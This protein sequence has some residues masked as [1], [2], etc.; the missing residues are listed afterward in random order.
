MKKSRITQHF[1]DLIGRVTIVQQQENVIFCHT[2]AIAHLQ[3]QFLLL[4]VVLLLQ[5]II[6]INPLAEP[7]T[8]LH[9]KGGVGQ[10]AIAVNLQD[11][12]LFHMQ[13]F[14]RILVETNFLQ[15]LFQNAFGRGINVKT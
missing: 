5:L 14:K 15:C 9:F 11:P 1:L 12:A 8:F 7:E 3:Q 2:I 6:P 4:G 10:K 13:H